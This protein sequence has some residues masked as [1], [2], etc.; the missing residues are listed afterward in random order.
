MYKEVHK[1]FV[2]E[3]AAYD[4]AIQ[5]YEVE[6]NR[7]K[8]KKEDAGDPPL[9]P[10]MPVEQRLVVGDVTTE[11]LASLLQENPLGLLLVRDELAAW[12]GTFDRYSR[13]KGADHPTWLSFHDGGVALVDRK[14]GP[15]TIF[16]ER[17]AVSVLGSI[18]PGT[19]CRVFGSAERES[20]LLAR[21]RLVQPPPRVSLYTDGELSPA[22]AA[23][24]AGLLHNL[25]AIQPGVD[26]EGEP[27][28]RYI[29]LAPKA[30]SVFRVWHDAHAHEVADIYTDDLAAY[31]S[32]LKGAVIR[33][34]LLFACVDVVTVGRPVSAIGPLHI[35]SAVRIV[36]WLK[37]EGRRVYGALSESDEQRDRRQLV[38]W[39]R[40][41]GG[42]VTVRELQRGRK[43]YT[44]S[45]DAEAALSE[46]AKA[47]EG[48]WEPVP[49]TVK[50]GRPSCV[51]RLSPVYE[52]PVNLG[53][54]E[55]LS[56]V[57]S[58]DTPN[59]QDD[60]WGEV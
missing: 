51:F 55:V 31:F 52:T 18:Q 48:T 4:A 20:G 49:T 58:V 50:G 27:R 11:K 59:T 40:R 34:A 28:P 13:G 35:E 10:A 14:T 22:T 46:L 29:R 42:A 44:T 33:L 57:D 26:D 5:R 56:D 6:C 39:I 45:G 41:R 8:Q 32:K 24:W 12:T 3:R 23:K 17:A 1:R 16:V 43:G 2:E 60:E 25:M 37:Y 9:K 21:L 53:G 54:K 47:G 7:W 38:E 36:E 15:G 19:L 30:L